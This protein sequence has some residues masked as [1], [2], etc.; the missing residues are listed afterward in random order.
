M[1]DI[2]SRLFGS[3]KEQH[4]KTDD[5]LLSLLDAKF[6]LPDRSSW[7]VFRPSTAIFTCILSMLWM[8]DTTLDEWWQLPEIGKFTGKFGDTLSGLWECTLMVRF[9]SQR[10][11]T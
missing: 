11:I 10:A 6:S 5:E 9:R 4:C 1:T 7:T 2:V 8:W 3:K